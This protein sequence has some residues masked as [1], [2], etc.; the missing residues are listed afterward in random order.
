MA[1]NPL[2]DLVSNLKKFDVTPTH[3]AITILGGFIVVVRNTS[4]AV[5]LFNA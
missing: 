1:D 3:L 5:L 4:L 2:S